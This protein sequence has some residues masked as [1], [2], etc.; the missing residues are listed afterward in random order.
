MFE[1]QVP[2]TPEKA[3]MGLLESL[4]LVYSSLSDHQKKDPFCVDLERRFWRGKRLLR[5]SICLKSYCVTN[6][7]VLKEDVM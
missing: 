2:E 6:P 7:F 4:P 1:G 3:Y 5:T